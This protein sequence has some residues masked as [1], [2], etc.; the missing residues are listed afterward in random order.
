MSLVTG[1]F[2]QVIRAHERLDMILV[3]SSRQFPFLLS[4]PPSVQHSITWFCIFIYRA[5]HATARSGKV[6]L[7]AIY[8]D[9]VVVVNNDIDVVVS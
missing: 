2:A 4:S 1:I 9:D 3:F 7:A 5:V 6:Y 8:N